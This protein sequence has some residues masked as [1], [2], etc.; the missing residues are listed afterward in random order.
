MILQQMVLH[1]NT[2][3]IGI[4]PF[5]GDFEELAGLLVPQITVS[6]ARESGIT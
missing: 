4:H 6:E 3:A 1:S 5:S 2:G